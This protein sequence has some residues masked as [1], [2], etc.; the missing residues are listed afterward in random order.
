MSNRLFL[1]SLKKKA[2]GVWVARGK[3]LRVK[4]SLGGHCLRLLE[5][6]SNRKLDNDVK[7]PRYKIIGRDASV[8]GGW[9]SDVR[10]PGE[11]FLIFNVI[12]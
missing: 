11:G 12:F 6:I 5:N 4:I 10:I 3:G 7:I 1:P 8:L 2:P 9:G